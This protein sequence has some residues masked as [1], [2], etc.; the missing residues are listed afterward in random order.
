MDKQE[1]LMVVGVFLA[2]FLVVFSFVSW[3]N[4]QNT[5]LYG[6]KLVA[7]GNPVE[8]L[9]EVF[10]QENR[11]LI[12]RQELT[13]G[14]TRENSAVAAASAELIYAGQVTGLNIYNYGVVNGVPVNGSCTSNNSQCGFPDITISIDSSASPCNCIA[15]SNNRTLAITGSTDFLL[16][17][18]ANLRKIVY[19]AR[20]N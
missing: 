9:K 14:S 17:N 15:L 13:E 20:S 16:E 6:F 2:V 8:L 7:N 11:S 4:S 12:L 10:N 3:L 1:A 18:A 19:V 5:Q